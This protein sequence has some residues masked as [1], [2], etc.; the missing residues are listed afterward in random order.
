[1]L[2]SSVPSYL[3]SFVCLED[4]HKGTFKKILKAIYQQAINTEILTN[5]TGIRFQHRFCRCG[6]AAQPLYILGGG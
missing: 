6:C 4:V 3:V 1:M 2:L 5:V